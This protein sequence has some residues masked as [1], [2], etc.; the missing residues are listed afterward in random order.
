MILGTNRTCFP[1]SVCRLVFVVVTAVSLLRFCR[2]QVF[3]HYV[4]DFQALKE[5]GLHLGGSKISRNS[6]IICRIKLMYKI[7]LSRSL[8]A[9]LL[10][11]PR[12][13]SQS[14]VHNV[15]RFIGVVPT[16]DVVSKSGQSTDC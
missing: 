1:D 13:H 16:R 9:I 10:N 4:E 11:I 8:S 15:T 14:S 5:R 7:L 3:K 6:G 2:Y 12:D